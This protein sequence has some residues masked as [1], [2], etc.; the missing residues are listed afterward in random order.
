[1]TVSCRSALS[2]VVLAHA[3]RHGAPQLTVDVGRL[4]WVNYRTVSL[5]YSRQWRS[6]AMASE[7]PSR[8]IT[9]KLV[10]S[11]RE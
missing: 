3:P 8:S 5:P 7:I 4:R 9:M 11:Q 1:M 2:R 6:N 10:A